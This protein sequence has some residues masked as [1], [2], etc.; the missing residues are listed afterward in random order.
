[1]RTPITLVICISV[2]LPHSAFADSIDSF[3]NKVKSKNLEIA[4]QGSMIEAAEARSK[5]YALKAPMIGVSQM[6]NMEGVSYQFEVQQ[7]VPLSNRLSSDK[8][9]RELSF[10]LQ[11]KESEFFSREKILEARL[12]FVNYW[13]SFE[14]I[15]YREEIRNWLKQHLAYARSVGRSD[16]S[17]TVYALEIESYLGIIENEISTV[18]SSIETEKSKLKEISFDEN[19]DPGIP[20]LD[21]E[22]PL[23]EASLTSRIS[24]INLSKLKIAKSELEVAKS[25]YLPNLF[26]R[27][28]KLDRQMI[29]M[30]NQ[31]IM[32]GID[33]PFAYF[34]QP[35][36]ENAMA[37]SNKY[38]AE[39]NHRKAEV[40]S[41]SL[42][43]SLK[44]KA[45]ILKNQLK[46]LKEVSI[47]AVEKALKY[48]KNIAPR[49]MTGLETHRRILQ[50]YIELKTQLLEIRMNY[51]EIYSN[52]SLLFAQG[53]SNE[54]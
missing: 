37:V 16:A 26:L 30:P 33:L 48:S 24:S 44:S 39:A 2:I 4:S 49:D 8:K 10:D 23:P 28:R 20:V 43:Q 13:K 34:W 32:V 36:A 22:K 9:S 12:A 11:K 5:G 51:E 54:F 21:E 53:N 52:W 29:G 38:V 17:A 50:D 18:Q 27:A 47:P 1:M 25:S 35:R 7:E 40:E 14:N 19:Y 15:K 3:L 6:K 45:A 42:K 31:E 46:T 41:E